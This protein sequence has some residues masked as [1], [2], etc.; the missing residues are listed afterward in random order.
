MTRFPPS[1][2]F[3]L[4]CSLGFLLLPLLLSGS[5]RPVSTPALLPQQAYIWQRHWTPALIRAMHDSEPLLTGWRV[6]G[7]ELSAQNDWLQTAPD[8]SAL[9]A[10][11]QPLSL[12]VRIDGQLNELH[13]TATIGRITAL[14][15]QWQQH[16][17]TLATVEIDHDC[18][19]ARLPAYTQFLRQLRLALHT[20]IALSITALPTWLDSPQLPALLAVPQQSVLQVHAVLNPRQGLF[21]AARARAWLRAYAQQTRHPWQVALPAYGTR[22][23]WDLQGRIRTIENE[24]ASLSASDGAVGAT[25][26]LLVSPQAMRAFAA[27][28]ERQPPPGLNGIVWFRLPTD[29][30]VRAWSLRSWQAVLARVPLRTALRIETRQRDG[31]L[32]DIVL[33]NDGNADARLP[34][35]IRLD[36][37]CQAADGIN[38]YTL[39]SDA[40]GNY[41]Q[42]TRDGLL[43][44]QAQR[45]IGWIRCQQ[46]RINLHVEP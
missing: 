46:S 36:A 43:R 14:V 29:D 25:Q 10:S 34:P 38:G 39:E 4:Y 30:D 42:R 13:D 7:A 2:W 5:Q 28:L 16:G 19:T 1:S 32:Q 33:R 41:L 27:Q 12:V 17:V 11:A 18:A 26:E 35:S 3:S 44:A 6:L 9:Q 22:V 8:W 24:Q 40:Q 20:D 21:D 45:N 31:E 15:A 37:S 23:S